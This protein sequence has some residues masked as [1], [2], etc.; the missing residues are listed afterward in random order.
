MKRILLLWL[1]GLSVLLAISGCDKDDRST[2]ANKGTVFDAVTLDPVPLAV[3]QAGDALSMTDADGA[4]LL[5]YLPEGEY[6]LKATKVGYT[7][8]TG[9][10][11]VVAGQ[12]AVQDIYLIPGGVVATVQGVVYD[13]VALT[14]VESAVVSIP[15]VSDVTVA[16][17]A[18]LLT[19]PSVPLGSVTIAAAAAGYQVYSALI[20]TQAG[21][22]VHHDIYLTPAAGPASFSPASAATGF[23]PL[24]TDTAE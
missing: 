20:T 3:V 15:P 24:N 18:Y 9:T 8:Y 1:V 21:V 17:G 16:D 11:T 23:T 7:D 12:V 14:P 5:G 19:G 22:T 6:V 4:Y 2:G 10:I 13:S